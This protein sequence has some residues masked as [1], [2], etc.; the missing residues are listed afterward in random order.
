MVGF[1]RIGLFAGGAVVSKFV[2]RVGLDNAA[3]MSAAAVVAGLAIY[4]LF[5]SYG[6]VW[7]AIALVVLSAGIRIVGSRHEQGCAY[8]AD[9]YAGATGKLGVALVT[10]GPGAANTLGAVGEAWASKSPVLV[11]ATDI[12]STQRRAGTH[13]GATW[14]FT[15][16]LKDFDVLTNRRHRQFSAGKN[17]DQRRS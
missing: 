13:R 1:S 8:A 12:P 6:Y 5:S 11:I 4:G 7:I 9:G 3:W 17:T 10:T 16:R 14:R 15:K 2:R